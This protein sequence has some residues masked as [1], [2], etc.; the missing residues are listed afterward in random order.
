MN[1]SNLDFSLT[2]ED[3]YDDLD[4]AKS[5]VSS[6]AVGR[7]RQLSTSTSATNST[8]PMKY[9]GQWSLVITKIYKHHSQSWIL[10]K[11]NVYFFIILQLAGSEYTGR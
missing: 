11:I 2:E 10:Y 4:E 3:D 7:K 9:Q 8:H 5:T 6:V 1:L